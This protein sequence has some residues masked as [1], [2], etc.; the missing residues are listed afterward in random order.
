MIKSEHIDIVCLVILLLIFFMALFLTHGAV[1][2]IDVFLL[3]GT[4]VLLGRTVGKMTL[5]KLENIRGDKKW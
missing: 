4:A 3:A 1:F 5:R 2:I